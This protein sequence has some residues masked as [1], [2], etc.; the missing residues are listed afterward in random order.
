MLA[1][2]YERGRDCRRARNQARDRAQGHSPPL[3]KTLRV[4]PRWIDLPH[5]R[6]NTTT[7]FSGRPPE[8]LSIQWGI[9]TKS[10][11]G[12]KLIAMEGPGGCASW[13]RLRLGVAFMAGWV[14]ESGTSF[15]A[16]GCDALRVILSIL[17]I[18]VVAVFRRH[19][20]AIQAVAGLRWSGTPWRLMCSRRSDRLF[21]TGLLPDAWPP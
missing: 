9:L 7:S 18:Q 19:C 4:Q 21:R 11:I 15:P 6:T 12:E 17:L 16:P 3:R 8:R 14:A 5:S 20:L 1:C 10:G 2:R 13:T